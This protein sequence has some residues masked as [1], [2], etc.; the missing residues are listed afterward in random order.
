MCL[1]LR[2]RETIG[3]VH[4][5]ISFPH[6]SA[7]ATPTSSGLRRDTNAARGRRLNNGKG[8]ETIKSVP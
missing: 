8:A 1:S 5:I 6:R 7:F 3:D 4:H 2:V